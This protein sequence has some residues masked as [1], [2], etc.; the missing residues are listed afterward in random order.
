MPLAELQTMSLGDTM[1]PTKAGASST[2]CSNCAIH[3]ICMPSGLNADDFSKLDSMN[4]T[5][6]KIRRGA[7]LYRTAD[8]FHSIYAIKAGSFK[9]AVVLNDG[10]EQIIGFHL[11]GDPIGLDGLSHEHHIYDAIALE[12]SVLCAISLPKLELLCRDLKS[13]QRHV[14]RWM[15]AEIAREAAMITLLGS[16]SAE[17]RVSCFLLNISQRMQARG[18]SSTDLRL[19]MTREEIGHYLGLKLETVSRV[20][21]R[22][23]NDQR[24]GVRGK[25]I[26]IIDP[27]RLQQ[28]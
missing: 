14:Y 27:D 7:A 19:H 23:H 22:F 16:M 5:S 12:D 1:T 24:I 20:L 15:C 4:F 8:P 28:P 9:T 10:R 11:T 6:H 21:S 13:M 3:H 25:T 26:R 2:N 17:E 18:R